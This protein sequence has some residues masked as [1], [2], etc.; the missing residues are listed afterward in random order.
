VGEQ[1]LSLLLNGPL[2]LAIC[3]AADGRWLRVNDAFLVLTGYGA[4]AMCDVSPAALGLWGDEAEA[5]RIMR[6][7]RRGTPV[8]GRELPFRHRDGEL[9]IGLVTVEPVALGGEECAL[10]LLQD[11]TARKRA[12]KAL[13]TQNSLLSALTAAQS[14]WIGHGDEHAPLD[15]LLRALVDATK[16]AFG[17]LAKVRDYDEPTAG[18]YYL[19]SCGLTDCAKSEEERAL[20]ARH[21]RRGL[22]LHDLDNFFGVV[23]ERGSVV[24]S[25]GELDL[26][27]GGW[28]PGAPPPQTVMGTTL[29][30]PGGD[31]VG[32]LVLADRPGGYLG[33]LA[34]ELGPFVAACGALLHAHNTVRLQ[35]RAERA[36]RE[37]EERFRLLVDGARDYALIMLDT[38]G[39]VTS[40]NEGARQITGH[41]ADEIVGM[42]VS[43]LYPEG[44]A[45]AAEREL[46]MADFEGRSEVEAERVRKG[47][48]RYFASVTLTALR[49][50]DGALCGF[51]QLT[52]DITSRKQLE[53]M[54]DEF[55]SIV[56]HELRTP[57]TAIRGALGLLGAGVAGE[58]PGEAQELIEL[59]G[60]NCERLVRLINDILDIQ[61]IEAGKMSLRLATLDPAVVVSRTVEQLRTWAGE[62]QVALA[63]QLD[64]A[65]PWHADEDRIS[66]VLTNLISNAVKFSP[67][68][69]TVRVTVKPAA[70]GARARVEV[71]DEGPGIPAE[72]RHLLFGKFQQ[73]D[74]SDSRKMGGTGL[75]LAICKAIV[76]LHGGTI[77]VESELGKGS[78]FWVELPLVTAPGQ[79]DET[80]HD[81]GAN[82]R[83]NPTARTCTDE[84]CPDRG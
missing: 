1:L 67:K 31:V 30:G 32:I 57:L 19:L 79:G 47:G 4:S 29:L 50:S 78:T 22:E 39:R 81:D 82:P 36:L 49:D 14:D 40:W 6:A 44:D 77:G 35:R 23:L 18:R 34:S 27:L 9:R 45:A 56:S 61:K 41:N 28:P 10:W 7:V 66:Q 21:Q 3:R 26:S 58:L 12:E 60:S 37:S 42:H 38:Y 54:K 43:R 13:Q 55:V 46:V 62:Q 80:D 75:G 5:A 68:G 17:V 76:E 51:A 2:A 33:V 63:H 52:R 83:P 59:A 71:A 74:G 24:A 8:H 20:Q 65:A 69:G 64:V 70:A 15:A 48:A 11:V 84:R 73:L 16:S 25:A 53:R 72:Q